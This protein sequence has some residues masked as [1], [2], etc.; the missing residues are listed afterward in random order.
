MA[1]APRVHVCRPQ[2]QSTSSKF[3]LVW[4]YERCN[5]ADQGDTLTELQDIAAS[6][7]SDLVLHKKSAGFLSWLEKPR[8]RVF[9]LA[10]WREAK[11]IMEGLSRQTAAKQPI[12]VCMCILA[13]SD[14]VYRRAT[15]WATLIR[16]SGGWN[17]KVLDGY[18]REGV[19]EFIMQS[20]EETMASRASRVV[21]GPSSPSQVSTFHTRDAAASSSSLPE[22]GQSSFN[23]SEEL[24][25]ASSSLSFVT[26]IRAVQDPQEAARLEE[27]IQRT[28]WQQ[29]YYED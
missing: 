25:S 27:M 29:P 6:F 7:G 28:M 17:I 19:E 12:R 3:C 26:L 11:P 16:Q 23:P 22:A 1:T 21:E 9:L 24:G 18:S 8:E 15:E 14:K 5:K 20:I 13:Q 2:E 4:C 10:D